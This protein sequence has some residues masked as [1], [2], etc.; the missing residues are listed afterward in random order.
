MGSKKLI[1]FGAVVGSTVGG[2]IPMLW[3]DSGL[4]A[5]SLLTGFLGGVFG[6]WGGYRLGESY[7]D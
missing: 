5:I 7:G 4:S 3:G 2:Y 6:I 1:M